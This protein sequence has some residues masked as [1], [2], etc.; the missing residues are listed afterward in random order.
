MT[1]KEQ[2]F[3]YRYFWNRIW[4]YNIAFDIT[5][6]QWFVSSAIVLSVFYSIHSQVLSLNIPLSRQV[7]MEPPSLRLGVNVVTI[8][9]RSR[10]TLIS[11][12]KAFVYGDVTAS[13]PLLASE[14]AAMGSR[15]MIKAWSKPG[16]HGCSLKKKSTQFSGLRT[17]SKSLEDISASWRRCDLQRNGQIRSIIVSKYKI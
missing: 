15:W 11:V 5:D 9:R 8:A 12:I 6:K 4:Y 7:N 10:S 14:A 13:P 16:C 3:I 17:S 2:S 1:K